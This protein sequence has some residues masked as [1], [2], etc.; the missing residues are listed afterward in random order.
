M[1]S[2]PDAPQVQ[3][4]KGAL[5]VMRGTLDSY[6]CAATS[7]QQP[8]SHQDSSSLLLGRTSKSDGKK[9]LEC[10]EDHTM[11][12]TLV[13]GG[14]VGRLWGLAAGW[15]VGWLATQEAATGQQVAHDRVVG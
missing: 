14:P 9:E 1:M 12:Q 13:G 3:A 5:G 11:F 8:S 6:L 15:L 4:A 2:M 7:A 10:I